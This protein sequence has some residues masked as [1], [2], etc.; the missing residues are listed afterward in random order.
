M[1]WIKHQ[2]GVNSSFERVGL[3]GNKERLFGGNR[4]GGG[5]L[6]CCG[7]ARTTAA[8]KT[9]DVAELLGYSE[10]NLTSTKG[11]EN[12]RLIGFGNSIPDSFLQGGLRRPG[13]YISENCPFKR[14]SL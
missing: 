3:A 1:R 7:A 8:V 10:P 14:V 4:G 5:A 11:L 13:L 2:T 9:A 6:G 12:A